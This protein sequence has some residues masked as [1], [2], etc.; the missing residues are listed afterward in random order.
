MNFQRWA[1]VGIVVY[2]GIAAL[3]RVIHIHNVVAYQND[4]LN[5]IEEKKPKFLADEIIPGTF[6][7]SSA[8]NIY[9]QTGLLYLGS[10]HSALQFDELRKR[11]ITHVVSV[12]REMFMP[13]HNLEHETKVILID[14]IRLKLL[15]DFTYMVVKAYDLPDQQLYKHFEVI[16]E[17]IEDAKAKGSAVLIHW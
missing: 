12:V 13:P 8:K 4:V 9:I 10:Y 14:L 17:F 1:L 7:V 5:A 6:L 3:I 15:K 16:H 11:N 2:I